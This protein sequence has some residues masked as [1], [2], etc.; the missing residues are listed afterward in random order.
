MLRKVD[1]EIEI[2]YCF[3]VRLRFRVGSIMDNG[4]SVS[5]PAV[6]MM[7][8]P[9]SMCDGACSNLRVRSPTS[10]GDP[11]WYCCLG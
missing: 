4:Q 3:G 8:T 1:A 9:S 6:M 7:M 11:R 2:D 5:T 10:N